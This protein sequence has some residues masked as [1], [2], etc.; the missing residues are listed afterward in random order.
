MLKKLKPLHL[1]IAFFA[2]GLIY[3]AFWI[4]SAQIIQKETRAF[5]ADMKTQEIITKSSPPK[6]GG[7]PAKHRLTI[8]DISFQPE[9]GIELKIPVITLTALPFAGST[10]TVRMDEGLVVSSKQDTELWSLDRLYFRGKIPSYLPATATHEDLNAWQKHEQ[11]MLQVD[12]FRIDKNLIHA[13]GAGTVALDD[14]LQPLGNLDV[15]IH[16]LLPFIGYLQ[17][18]GIIDVK[19]TLTATAVLNAFSRRNPETGQQYVFI[20]VKLQHQA[21]FLGPIEIMKIPFIRW[22]WKSVLPKNY[23]YDAFE[24]TS[25]S[26]SPSP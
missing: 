14:D 13:R 20:P 10:L 2:L 1:L 5:L 21:M 17:N 24:Q 11:S 3:S 16:G 6:I 15:E 18:K 8:R 22:P 7:F 4:Y 19:E 26:I 12:E 23:D 9:K 25:E